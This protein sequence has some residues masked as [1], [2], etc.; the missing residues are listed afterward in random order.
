MTLQL[1]S[2]KQRKIKRMA[3][4]AVSVTEEFLLKKSAELA[5]VKVFRDKDG[6]LLWTAYLRD[7]VKLGNIKLTCWSICQGKF[8]GRWQK[9]SF[10]CVT[11][12]FHTCLILRMPN[13]WGCKIIDLHL[14]N[15]PSQSAD[16]ALLDSFLS[17]NLRKY[18]KVNHFESNEGVKEADESWFR[19]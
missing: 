15:K 16:L 8:H 17:P 18:L 4:Q 19:N 12:H 2:E 14:F 7:I 6:T 13:Q 5:T 1:R 3:S 11:M 10:F 9:S